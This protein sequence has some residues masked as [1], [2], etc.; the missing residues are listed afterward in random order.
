MFIFSLFFFKYIS[1]S[2][3]VSQCVLEEENSR[4]WLLW[5]CSWNEWRSWLVLCVLRCIEGCKS[6][7]MSLVS[8]LLIFATEKNI[9]WYLFLRT[10]LCLKSQTVL[11][12]TYI[13]L[14]ILEVMAGAGSTFQ[15][16][17]SHGNTRFFLLGVEIS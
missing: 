16:P 3:K 8:W 17:A 14:H 9:I 2:I 1:D 12:G 7:A 15:V 13:F 10:K 6:T 11:Y 5:S 4:S